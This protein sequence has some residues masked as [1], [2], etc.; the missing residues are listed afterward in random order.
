MLIF[1]NK[2][3]KRL[4]G[5]TS[6]KDL[7]LK[8]YGLN[9]LFIIIVAMACNVAPQDSQT[10]KSES[11]A[12]DF[13]T[14]NYNQKFSFNTAVET[15]TETNGVFTTMLTRTGANFPQTQNVIMRLG[16]TA[17]NE[18]LSAILV[19]GAPAVFISSTQFIATFPEGTNSLSVSLVTFDDTI[20]EEQEFFKISLEPNGR[21]YGITGNTEFSVIIND[22]DQYP[23]ASFATS[24]Y[25]GNEGTNINVT[26]SVSNLTEGD[27]HIPI[28]F[29]ASGS[30]VTQNDTN[31]SN[32]T[33]VFNQTTGMVQQISIQLSNDIFNEL[34]EVLKLKI[35]TPLQAIVGPIPSTE[36]TIQDSGALPSY[37]LSSSTYSF[38]ESGGGNQFNLVLQMTGTVE[39]E[40][41]VPISTVITA[42]NI[43]E[44]VDYTKSNSTFIIPAGSTNATS[45]ITFTAIDDNI[46]EGNESFDVSIP[47]TTYANAFGNTTAAI[48][49]NDVGETAPTIGFIATNYQTTEG[50]T[51]QLPIEL[52]FRSSVPIT[53]DYVVDT[54]S[55]DSAT[56]GTD[57]SLLASGTFTI[58]AG[59]KIFTRPILISN[60]GIYDQGE[61]IRITISN[62]SQGSIGTA[63]SSININEAGG[64]ATVSFATAL[65][66]GTEGTTSQVDLTLSKVSQNP[67]SFK[68]LVDEIGA[69]SLD[70]DDLVDISANCTIAKDVPTEHRYTI[71]IAAGETNCPIGIPIITN[72]DT[73]DEPTEEIRLRILQPETLNIGTIGLHNFNIEDDDAPSTAT[74]SVANATVDE[75]LSET[76]TITLDKASGFDLYINIGVDGS[77]QA[78]IN[79]DYTLSTQ[80]VLIQ[81]GQTTQTFTLDS[82][83]DGNFEDANE[84]VV[85]NIDAGPNYTIG[86]PATQSIE[87]TELES[88]PLVSIR[89]ALSENFNENDIVNIIFELDKPTYQNILV[90]FERN[91][92]GT[93]CD[94]A[95][96]PPVAPNECAIMAE[97]V[98]EL[99]AHVGY[100]IIPAGST[101][102]SLS[103]KILADNLFELDR[104]EAFEIALDSVS[105][106]N[107]YT[108][109]GLGNPD[110]ITP[111]P[112]IAPGAVTAKE[113]IITDVDV[114]SVARFIGDKFVVKNEGDATS[115]VIPFFLTTPSAQD[116]TFKVM[117][118]QSEDTETYKPDAND[119]TPGA[120]FYDLTEPSGTQNV[121]TEINPG[122]PATALD[123]S[124]SD[125]IIYQRLVTIPAGESSYNIVLDLNSGDTIYENIEQFIVEIDVDDIAPPTYYPYTVNN[126]HNTFVVNIIEKDAVPSVSL[127]T[128]P[129]DQPEG[130][131]NT[132][133]AGDAGVSAIQVAADGTAAQALTKTS[134]DF[135]F[136]VSAFHQ[137]EAMTFTLAF[138]GSAKFIANYTTKD[139]FM[140]EDYMLDIPGPT[141]NTLINSSGSSIEFTIPAAYDDAPTL[142]ETITTLIFADFQFETDET[143][144]ATLQDADI[145]TL[146]SPASHTL[147]IENDDKPPA[148]VALIDEQSF[149]FTMEESEGL[150][151]VDVY[152]SDDAG[153]FTGEFITEVPFTLA[154][155]VETSRRQTVSVTPYANINLSINEASAFRT[156]F[157]VSPTL[158]GDY[159]RYRQINL[160]FDPEDGKTSNDLG[161]TS[162]ITLEVPEPKLALSKSGDT[163]GTNFKGH[164][165]SLYRGQVTCFGNNE[166]GQLGRENTINFGGNP[167]D[168]VTSQAQVINFGVNNFGVAHYIKDIA[169]GKNH[170]CVLT[171]TNEVKCFGDN[172]FGQLGY[173]NTSNYGDT[174][175]S[176]GASLP[177]VNLG[178]TDEVDSII[179]LN[180]STCALMGGTTIKC[181]GKNDVGQAGIGNID[182]TDIGSSSSEMSTN[183][184]PVT[185]S[186]VEID[187]I[188][189]GGEH[190]CARI[191]NTNEL[192]C[193]GRNVESQLGLNNSLFVFSDLNHGDEPGEPGL[194]ANL[195]TA[196]TITS[197]SLGQRHTCVTFSGATFNTRCFGD[198]RAGQLGMGRTFSLGRDLNPLYTSTPSNILYYLGSSINFQ[199]YEDLES[200]GDSASP[201]NVPVAAITNNQYVQIREPASSLASGDSHTC[202]TYDHYYNQTGVRTLGKNIRCW[203][204]SYKYGTTL[205]TGALNNIGTSDDFGG[206]WNSVQLRPYPLTAGQNDI[207]KQNLRFIGDGSYNSNGAQNPLYTFVENSFLA[208]HEYG[209][210]SNFFTDGAF[211]TL[212]FE[213][214]YLYS[215]SRDSL[216]IWANGIDDIKV[217]SGGE[218]VCAYLE[219]T[220]QNQ[221]EQINDRYQFMCWGANA[222]GQTG[223]ATATCAK[224]GSSLACANTALPLRKLNYTY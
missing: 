209:W 144:I 111:Y 67:Q 77:S 112:T 16:G 74:L 95:P 187:M 23:T 6:D 171:S 141:G 3:P 158:T 136:T 153:V 207:Y 99:D 84:L 53:I 211:R 46:W 5:Y 37:S 170:T 206:I 17:E 151:T 194:S 179:A 87:I 21:D 167:S 126:A 183:L 214:N 26:V 50:N 120:N 119:F 114:P 104:P 135:A 11:N 78:T 174:T 212:N 20:F 173:G 142:T 160:N 48:T 97:D 73:L 80:S 193:W 157:D 188:A 176:M 192:K 196:L 4:I 121:G 44:G 185:F 178:S 55:L 69:T 182:D 145:I 189:G 143:I 30:T 123:Y 63:S 154:V 200:I 22:N 140:T 190:A 113:I 52:D 203:G 93:F 7:L 10:P 219:D 109:D 163:V 31:F 2:Y 218:H 204:S 47:N 133:A 205:E 201:G 41:V 51:F 98:P 94:T 96:A 27:I 106:A 1:I 28:V 180:H 36:I 129:L 35:E 57:H 172:Q 33:L 105:A 146:G 181:W 127:T 177:T 72:D 198:N 220:S 40:I 164:T 71:T 68:I 184:T 49:L 213:L 156:S 43:I 175:G 90:R 12:V 13:P 134:L 168:T 221:F 89:G 148:L 195:N 118:K 132:T 8:F 81:K 208:D 131:D 79:T 14:L 124:S 152:P 197:M 166:F 139:Q 34:D 150:K 199:G 58:P 224:P 202:G 75:G 92:T 137:H 159:R 210:V 215:M 15:T 83:A 39:N 110:V 103:F 155:E 191:T 85:L 9:I 101:Q 61:K 62:P 38:N 108:V 165:C 56:P 29:D 115:L 64:L 162:Q 102:A 223:T 222:N 161:M 149:P 147:T 25:S 82:I 45:T 216:N 54:V 138:T 66:T 91:F 130:L 76:F 70:F 107:T 186:G 42:G 86:V 117:I 19:N 122:R 65:S 24:T 18:D 100:V 88:A 60:D 169:L 217:Y 128:L 116:T 59:T 32:Q 125:N